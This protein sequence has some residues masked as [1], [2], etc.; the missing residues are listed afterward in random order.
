VTTR[1]TLLRTSAL[2]AAV[3]VLT[4]S[5]ASCTGTTVVD[6]VLGAH[7]PGGRQD[8]CVPNVVPPSVRAKLLDA[9]RAAAQE[10]HG[11]VTRVVAAQS[12]REEAAHLT[13][14]TV[15]GDAFVWVVEV[16]GHFRCGDDCFF[17]AAP[18]RGTVLTLLVDTATFRTAGFG[19]S[20]TWV[21]LSH[22][23]PVVV[24]SR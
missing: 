2:G 10:N 20:N 3:V 13:D 9:A 17:V 6:C 1:L 7:H 11:S 5:L 16:A 4:L 24:L 22:L 12:T 19:L 15:P 21:D 14:A 18:P 8:A 23:G